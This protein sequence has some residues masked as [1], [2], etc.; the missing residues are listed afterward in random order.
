MVVVVVRMALAE[1]EVAV[2]EEAL[3]P[4]WSLSQPPN[5]PQLKNSLPSLRIPLSPPFEGYPPCS[6]SKKRSPLPPAG[7]TLC[8]TLRRCYKRCCVC[9]WT[10]SRL[11]LQQQRKRWLRGSV[12]CQ[13]HQLIQHRPQLLLCLDL[14]LDLAFWMRFFPF[15]LLERFLLIPSFITE[16]LLLLKV[17][18]P[19]L[20]HLVK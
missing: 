5:T 10:W 6:S 14:M 18:L 2:E 15:F 11:Y 9:C 12:N 17:L 1:E 13:L 20:F 19:S 4:R 7:N 3:L 8:V 16:V